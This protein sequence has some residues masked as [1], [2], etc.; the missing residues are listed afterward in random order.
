MRRALPLVLLLLALS[1]ALVAPALAGGP[2]GEILV[3]RRGKVLGFDK[4]V[5]ETLHEV[6]IETWSCETAKL[7]KT[8]R[9]EAYYHLSEDREIITPRQVC[10][11]CQAKFQIEKREGKYFF[12]SAEPKADP[13]ATGGAKAPSP[14]PPPAAAPPAGTPAPTAAATTAPISSERDAEALDELKKK[15][16]T[17]A[18][19]IRKIDPREIGSAKKRR[20]IV[21]DKALQYAF[22]QFPD[23]TKAIEAVAQ[24][25]DEVKDLAK[26]DRYY[27][28]RSFGWQRYHVQDLQAAG[29][30]YQR[31]TKLIPEYASGHYQYALVLKEQK[32]REGEIVE[33]GRA[34]RAKPRIK[35]AKL[36]L[37][38]LK[39]TTRVSEKLD[40]KTVELLRDGVAEAKS[41]FEQSPPDNPGA[42]DAIEKTVGKVLDEKYPQEK[43]GV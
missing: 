17:A 15:V 41:R 31:C 11:R 23:K 24:A 1:M 5:G 18:Y 8:E 32:N 29:I 25:I 9:V 10:D 3:Y 14:P 30:F 34:L 36:L 28:L 21:E 40:E 13:K 26:P 19:E 20:K 37:D 35:Y 6:L 38:V 16:A 42:K 2:S 7:V 4:E 22:E 39:L 43:S 12:V 27:V 33:L